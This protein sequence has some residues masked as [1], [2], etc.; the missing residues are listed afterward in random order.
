MLAPWLPVVA[1]PSKVELIPSVYVRSA[2]VPA[3]NV[4]A[5]ETTS[6][7]ILDTRPTPTMVNVLF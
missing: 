5:D 7:A 4:L 3:L 6:G 1:A 2:A